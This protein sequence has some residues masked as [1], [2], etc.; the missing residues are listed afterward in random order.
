MF[1]YRF[2][3]VS[4]ESDISVHRG[5]AELNLHA[6]LVL[7]IFVLVLVVVDFIFGLIAAILERNVPNFLVRHFI[8][9][10]RYSRVSRSTP[11]ARARR[12]NTRISLT[13]HVGSLGRNEIDQS[14]KQFDGEVA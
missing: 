2:D 5:C 7:V 10:E 6:L 12:I 11:G 14:R 9:D 8:G 4:N 1:L 3:D 13:R